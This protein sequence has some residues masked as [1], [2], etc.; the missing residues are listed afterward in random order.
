MSLLFTAARIGSLE[1]PNRL[2]RSATAELL[3][4]ANGRPLPKL[5]SM[6]QELA[7]G[8]VGLIITGHM[9]VHPDG[10]AHPHMMG[11]YSDTLLPGLAE[12]A[13]VVHAEGGYVAVQ[14]NHGGMH[15]SD[16][17]VKEAIAPSNVRASLARRTAR[18][19]TTAE[20]EMLIDA[21]AQAAHRVREAG[22]DAVQIHSA[23]GYLI[24]QFLS[25]LVNKRTDQWGGDA[26]GRMRFLRAVCRAVR[27]QVGP[28]YPVFVKL[29]LQDEY[30][31]GLSLEE[32]LQVVGS[33]ESMDLD[34]VEISVGLGTSS[35]KGT[36]T[37]EDE[38]YFR[39]WAHKSRRMT[40]LPII[41][42]GGLRSRGM[43][44]A[45]LA[46]GDADF[47]SL[48][49]PLICEP[50]LPNRMRLGQQERSSCISANQCWEEE[51]GVGISCKC[52]LEKM[53]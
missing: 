26:A 7:R 24:S 14:I 30:E 28:D 6:Y 25:P 29:G 41:L 39:P 4:D 13:S 34:A 17:S 31:G 36:R 16:P 12:L 46:A 11:I 5:K 27:G 52:P 38:A 22:F 50:D 10:K 20:V 53:A 32:G 23:H 33:L 19:M 21:Y 48:C 49:R 43:M 1:L 51:Y 8:G 42:V 2:V 18:E 9:Y 45:V 44:E 15:A 40:D 35:R 3:A 37:A 47:I